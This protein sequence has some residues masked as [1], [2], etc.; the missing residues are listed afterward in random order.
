VNWLAHVFLS[1][2]SIEFQLGNLL[3]DIVKGED[4][5]TMSAEFLRGV[6][7]HHAIDS[8]TD[9]HPVV[10]RS[11]ARVSSEHR[12]FSGVLIDVFYDHFLSIDWQRYSTE[13]LPSFTARFY[14]AAQAHPIALPEPARL[15]L[16]R[17]IQYDLLSSYREV[18]GVEE[19]LRRLS[20]RLAKR[21]RRSFALEASVADLVAQHEHFARDFAEFFPALRAHVDQSGVAAATAP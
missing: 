8:F 12:R 19:S 11:R 9:A 3:A 10:R 18:D 13:S 20:M 6:H 2:P 17:I 15:A 5:K 16:D 14:E 1:T 21:W 7:R 4:R